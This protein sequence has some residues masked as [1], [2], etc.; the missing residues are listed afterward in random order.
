MFYLINKWI[1][2]EMDQLP[3]EMEQNVFV[4]KV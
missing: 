4:D 3:A 1:V 2:I